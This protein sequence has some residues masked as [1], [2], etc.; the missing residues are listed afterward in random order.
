MIIIESGK[1]TIKTF[2]LA[3]VIALFFGLILQN[4]IINKQNILYKQRI[5][6]N[7]KLLD[8]LLFTLSNNSYQ[9]EYNMYYIRKYSRK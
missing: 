7:S 6:E 2:L 9:Y 5:D 1:D 8:T 4:D 3:L